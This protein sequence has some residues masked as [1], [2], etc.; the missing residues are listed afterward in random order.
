MSDTDNGKS[1]ASPETIGPVKIEWNWDMDDQWIETTSITLGD[2]KYE[3]GD[4]G[5]YR[6]KARCKRCWG[7]LIAKRDDNCPIQ[8]IRCRVCNLLLEG[9]AARTEF[10]GM[11]EEQTSHAFNL[12]LGL[13]TRYRDEG[14]CVQKVFPRL[15]RQSE[16]EIRQ[17]VLARARE[18][19]KQGWI[20][21]SNFPAG[22]AGYL[23]L[24]A[25]TLM[26][27]V[28]RLP[29]EFSV[30]P[31]PDFDFNDNG[32]ATVRLSREELGK[33]TRTQEYELMQRLG[34]TTT[35]AMMSAFAC[36]LAMKAIRLTL[37]DEARKSHDLW[38]LYCDLP[39]NSQKRIETD[40]PEIAEV[41]RKSRHTFDKWR[42][43]EANVGGKGIKAMIDTE[44]A[45]TLAKAAR[46]IL[47]EAEIVGLGYSVNVVANQ[48]VTESAEKRDIHIK[49]DMTVKVTEAPPK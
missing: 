30:A 33:H 17:R 12:A 43:F 25:R 47:D 36:E 29:R 26:A 34:T 3:P 20:T 44:R 48:H 16:E 22:S 18:G 24:Q 46:V 32:S 38:E 2:K 6:L 19:K 31:F 21:R 9:D 23:F 15:A 1:A 27:G 10:Q 28:Q 40:Y 4:E 42:Y 41:L 7:G 13:P 5:R 35:V 45:F 8:A 14:K 37:L 11:S 39:G 49:Q